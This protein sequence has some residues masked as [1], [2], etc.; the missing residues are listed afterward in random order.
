MP[1]VAALSGP[2]LA[3]LGAQTL[4]AA[5]DQ[6]LGAGVLTVAFDNSALSVGVALSGGQK[7][8]IDGLTIGDQGLAGRLY[9]EGLDANPLS[10]TLFDG[11]D[12]A[13]TAFDVTLANG[14]LAASHIG[15]RLTIP[16][17]TDSNG[18]P[19]T[20]AIEI[21]FKS[22]GTVSVSLAAVDDGN[23]ATPDGLVHLDYDIGSAIDLS[24][25][26]ASLEVDRAPDGSWR[27]LLSGAL[28]IS[29][30]GMAW[31]SFELRGLGI[32]RHGHITV[33]G[34]WINLPHQMALDFHGF[35]VALEKIGFGQDG[36]GRWIGF[37]GE[38]YLVE[39]L[40]LGGSVRGLRINLD[41]GAISFD[42]VGIAF[43]IPD[44]L[45]FEGEI[46]HIHVDA[47]TP[48]DLE[49]A[50]LLP[51]IFN[52][53]TA[54]PDG[55]KRVNVFAGQVKLHIISIDL[56]VDANFIVGHFGGQSVFFLDI[57][58]DLPVGIPIFL[59]VSLYGMEGLVAGGLR[60]HPE[61]DHTWWEWY[62]YPMGLNGP[63]TSKPSDYNA[64]DVNKWMSPEP[65]AFAIGAGATIGTSADDGFTVSAAITFVLMLPGPVISLIGKANILSKRI[66]SAQQEANFEA[67]ATF[68][69]NAGTFDLT[70]DAQYKIPVVLDIEGTAE[71]FVDTTAPDWYF[72][73]GKPPHDKRIKARIFDLFE[74]DAYFVVGAPGLVTGTWTGYRGAWSY[75][76]LS[77]SLDAYLATLAAIQWS[78]LQIAGGIELHGDVQLHVFGIG[79][80]I[81]ADA[82]L[83]GC[84]PN[85]FWVHGEISV[86][87]KTP[88][89]LPDV[90]AT[91]SLT[92]GGDDGSVP[93][94]PLALSHV[95]ITLNDHADP[96]DKA[97]SDRYAL[98]AHR[99]E[100]PRPDAVVQYDNPS[101]PGILINHPAPAN[102]PPNN[103][104]LIQQA[105][106]VPQDAHFTLTF[107]H[108]TVDLAGF[109][110]AKVE[111]ALPKDYVTVQLPSIV[112]P[113]DMSNL[114]PTPPAPQWAYRHSLIEVVL[115]EW[116]GSAWNKVCSFPPP[117]NDSPPVGVT[118]LDGVWLEQDKANQV[119]TQLKVFPWRLLPGQSWSA[120]W[121]ADTAL[122]IQKSDFDD[123][124]LHF[125]LD[126][127]SVQ[128]A[129][130]PGSGLPAGLQFEMQNSKKPYTV[131]IRFPFKVQISSIMAVDYVIDGEF[132][133]KFSPSWRGD[134]QA[135]NPTSA[136]Q[137]V[138]G[139]WTQTF[140]S[141]AAAILELEVTP[142]GALQLFAIAYNSANIPM[143]ILPDPHALYALKT[144]TK[145]A[146]GRANGSSQP[147]YQD[148]AGGNP[149]VEFA[150]FQ[151]VAGPGTTVIPQQLPG[152]PP[153]P[154][155]HAAFPPLSVKC[156]DQQQPPAAFPR[157]G[158]LDDLHTYTEWSW[159]QDG[160]IAA[161]YG[162]DVNVEFEETYVNALYTYFSSG[163]VADAL[164][165][166]CVDRN[167]NHTLLMPVA[168]HVPSI[169]PQ[170]ALVAGE[171][172]APL[173]SP[174]ADQPKNPIRIVDTPLTVTPASA[175]ASV[176]NNNTGKTVS[177]VQGK[178]V[179]TPRSRVLDAL[180][181]RAS[182]SSNADVTPSGDPLLKSAVVSASN[183]QLKDLFGHN[184][185][186]LVQQMDP[187][188][189]AWLLHE[190]QEEQDAAA[191]RALWFKPLLPLTR[192]TLDVVAGPFNRSPRQWKPSEGGTEGTLA[193]I[194][195]ATDATG[196]L[197]T[198]KAY[199]AYED[200]LTALQ[201]VQ[202]TTSRYATFGAQMANVAKQMAGAPGATSI[203]HYAA[204]TD[205]AAWITNPANDG[206]R[207]TA[208][209]N[210]NTA[211]Q[212]LANVVANFDPL[213]DDR[214]PDGS[215]APFGNAA[216][217]DK[218]DATTQT[219]Q[220]LL[221]ATTN[222]FDGLIA[223]LGRPDLV[224]RAKPVPVPD[225]EL[226][227]FTDA[228]GAFVRALLIES[229]EPL[230][231]RRIRKSISLT[232]NGS[233]S[234]LKGII[235]L[236][237][238][239]GTRGL[240]IIQGTARGPYQLRM[241]FQGNIGAEAP[242]ITRNAKPIME[243]V[244]LG[245]LPLGPTRIIVQVPIAS[246][247]AASG[248][249][250]PIEGALN[251]TN[252]VRTAHAKSKRAKPSK[253]G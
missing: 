241:T 132:S 98:L 127:H 112:E 200:A 168:I 5:A 167:Q 210:H 232:P 42:G 213:A 173:P 178:V 88:W 142:S 163:S 44:V 84:A 85:P 34:G 12:V 207:S 191:A 251:A 87:L 204:S 60:P 15:G 198:L 217:V 83:E 32:D 102:D 214:Q 93:P 162:Y 121:G 212:A 97:S 219:W 77:V 227:L 197:A 30:E 231:W 155:A 222:S 63:D 154:M 115:Y 240:I 20:V 181:Q 40:K 95:D 28:G 187:A 209:G 76:P 57:A 96:A 152:P 253:K 3:H 234:G 105:P 70:I 188:L 159:P 190:L 27:I 82:L 75:G 117:S 235:V 64:T 248:S 139:A 137:D 153:A 143:A 161:Y 99:P 216:L 203:R 149:I 1:N 51:T 81:T 101:R 56:E 136:T 238:G 54:D 174:I 37:S 62:K 225:T 228:S 46:D 91:V 147:A 72:A 175:G 229:P 243:T 126:A 47:V 48:H 134:G 39:G 89:P 14:G 164:H 24:I 148:V 18:D 129:T 68:D 211:R 171:V 13:L 17:F 104:T 233:A 179:G 10:A 36:S 244:N 176:S 151:T 218:R 230:P 215:P 110:A 160:A 124:G 45:T 196:V 111:S 9:V 123:Q 220:T 199:L 223:A 208:E 172:I 165:F 138:S 67:M 146:A 61:P 201:R 118:Q 79:L 236:W 55:I 169:P 22:D 182:L 65:G 94:A 250:K 25:D 21:S 86:E 186:V 131:K 92:W 237:N 114:N 52:Q 66:G 249:R 23:P 38:V 193:A 125:S 90:S 103:L 245:S 246:S 130:P 141:T 58:A 59:D 108:P 150:Y 135:L 16:F 189:A 8:N 113:D 184:G 183:L 194:Y 122:T 224:S 205:P 192:Y 206:T 78:P 221:D 31:P 106:V 71:L 226:T 19:K 26:V 53:I 156:G 239:D 247:V 7:V 109:R 2:L 35:H 120:Q 177:K 33:D 185:G 180:V 69:G 144:V 133:N 11:F 145:V 49:N 157:G 41:T 252:R 50:G 158:A 100:G 202:F 4:Q 73:L 195:M 29:S 140:A 119:Q 43:E 74:S 6:T 170:S 80:G 107:A 166:R 116:A 242:S 128:I